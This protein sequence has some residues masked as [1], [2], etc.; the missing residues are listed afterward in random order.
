MYPPFDIVPP[1]V[2]AIHGMSAAA[3]LNHCCLPACPP[4]CL[5]CRIDKNWVA[6]AAVWG[7]LA[8]Y[9]NHSCNPNCIPKVFYVEGVA[10]MGIYAKRDL[11]LGEELCYDYKVCGEGAMWCTRYVGARI[12]SDHLEGSCRMS[13]T[14]PWLCLAS[15]VLSVTV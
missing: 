2:C 5:A 1:V 7:G 14:M 15:S 12:G 4:A 3:K 10:R 8:R 11:K 9:I 6:D 13:I